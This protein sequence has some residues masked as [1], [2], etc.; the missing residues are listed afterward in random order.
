MSRLRQ[1]VASGPP[2]RLL[3]CSPFFH[4]SETESLTVAPISRLSFCALSHWPTRLSSPSFSLGRT[5]KLSL[6]CGP[7]AAIGAAHASSRKAPARMIYPRAPSSPAP[8]CSPVE[9]GPKNGPPLA[10]NCAFW[11]P[12]CGQSF[13]TL[14]P[15]QPAR[16]VSNL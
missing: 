15:R 1:S 5:N 4:H 8:N 9:W 16:P 2:F 3:F 11:A 6:P 13:V 14:R 7:L 12:S 10:H